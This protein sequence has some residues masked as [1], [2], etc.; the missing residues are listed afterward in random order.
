MVALGVV[1]LS[2][3]VWAVADPAGFFTTFPGAGH[4]WTAAYPP[5]NGHLVT[6]LGATFL[7]LGVL[8]IV[9]GVVRSLAAA[10]M[11]LL[12]VVLFSTVH[13]AFHATHH[14]SLHGLD[15]TASLATLAG[16]VLGPAV[17]WLLLEH[18]RRRSA[19]SR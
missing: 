12:A 14:G 2:W 10:R 8:T 17:L 7:T 13:L 3:G 19:Q 1:M 9:G 15:L 11:A 16:G 4:R 6:D 5:Y 18:D